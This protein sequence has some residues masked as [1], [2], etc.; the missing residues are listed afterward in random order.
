[1]ELYKAG[2]FGNFISGGLLGGGKSVASLGMA[3]QNINVGG[4]FKI[5]GSDLYAS[6]SRHGNMLNGNT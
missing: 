2:S 1:L 6:V 4:E 3:S 5:R